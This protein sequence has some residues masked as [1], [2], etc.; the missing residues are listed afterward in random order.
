MR[1]FFVGLGLHLGADFLRLMAKGVDLMCVYMT[2]Q[3]FC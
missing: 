3:S 2:H 1:D